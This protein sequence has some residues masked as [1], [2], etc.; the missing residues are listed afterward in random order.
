MLV[1]VAPSL[2]GMVGEVGPGSP[3]VGLLLCAAESDCL[4]EA[5]WFADHP[6]SSTLP[7]MFFTQALGDAGDLY[8]RQLESRQAFRDAVTD[9]RAAA[10]AEGDASGA[11]QRAD[12]ALAAATGVIGHQLLFEHAFLHGVEALRRGERDAQAWFSRAAS[13][14]W[15]R[16]VRL[17]VVSPAITSAWQAG[18]HAV[19][20]ARRATVR[21]AA[22]P[23]GA[24]WAVDGVDLGVGELR[25]EVFPGR[26]RFT[27]T[28]ERARTAVLLVDV[29]AGGTT[30]LAAL[31]PP[32]AE[33]ATLH[34]SVTTVF[35]GGPADPTVEAALGAWATQRGV[36][37][38]VLLYVA[39]G[40]QRLCALSLRPGRPLEVPPGALG[41][42]APVPQ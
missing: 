33:A 26:H 41:C 34:A 40:P 7:T 20:H 32:E 13:V 42:V 35:A 16:E 31:F 18:Q 17:P 19:L 28:T 39:T 23:E 12:Q 11:L 14:A 30:E 25:V 1:L 3:R 29:P 6:V 22:A 36:G 8:A 10:A 37:E 2:A 24:A 4:A 5:R 9:A 21:L 27:A 38:L 15:T